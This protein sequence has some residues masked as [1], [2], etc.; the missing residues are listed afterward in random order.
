MCVSGEIYDLSDEQWKLVDE[1]MEFY[2]K[3]SAVI[4]S[5]NLSYLRQETISYNHPVGNQLAIKEMGSKKLVILHRFENS[6]SENLEFMREYKVIS[7]YG[8]AEDDFSAKAWL[9]EKKK[10]D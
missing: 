2:R 6:H 1:G 9:L 3:A 4:K 7:E 5:G 8:S 10:N